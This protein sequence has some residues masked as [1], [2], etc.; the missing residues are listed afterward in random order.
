MEPN[1]LVAHS[2]LG[3]VYVQQGLYEMAM[4]EYRKVLELS[5]GVAVVETAMKAVIAHAYAKWGKRSKALKL[6]DELTKASSASSAEASSVSPH[7]IAEVYAALGQSDQAFE[8][9]NKACDQ[10]DMPM[11]SMK[12]NPTLD[13]LR[14]DPRF[15]D[16]VRRVGL[17]Q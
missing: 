4:A 6:L 17:L 14:A 11:V 8:W 1:F 9:L 2:V 15:A 3:N 10:H 7:S 12:T 5:K 16:L 13:R